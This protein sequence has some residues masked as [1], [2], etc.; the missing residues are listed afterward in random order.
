MPQLN[1]QRG[2]TVDNTDVLSASDLENLPG[3]GAL[4]VYAASTAADTTITVTPPGVQSP[5]RAVNLTQ[6]AVATVNVNDD[7]PLAMV[8]ILASGRCIVAVDVVTGGTWA[9]LFVYLPS[10]EA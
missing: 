7:Q 9:A 4:A 10:D 1:V 6:K 3:P 5:A 8:P 2:G